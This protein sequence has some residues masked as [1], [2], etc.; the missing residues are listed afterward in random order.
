MLA[1]FKMGFAVKRD[2]DK[3]VKKGERVMISGSL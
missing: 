2:F 3:I 1:Y